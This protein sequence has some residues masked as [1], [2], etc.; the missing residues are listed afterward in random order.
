MIA[1]RFADFMMNE[2]MFLEEV[3]LTYFERSDSE[4]TMPEPMLESIPEP[5]PEPMPEPEP[6]PM[7]EQDEYIS[8][9]L[10]P[11]SSILVTTTTSPSQQPEDGAQPEPEPMPEVDAFDDADAVADSVFD[12]FSISSVDT[13]DFDMDEYVQRR[14]N[15]RQN[16]QL[17]EQRNKQLNEQIDERGGYKC[18]IC[19]DTCVDLRA[20]LCGHVFCRACLY[21]TFVEVSDK[22]PKCRKNF[23]LEEC[24]KVF[25]D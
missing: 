12:A 21:K 5:M 14:R 24:L 4:R 2:R 1:E 23:M 18:P 9:S 22:C 7:P 8:D 19:L 13:V 17:I 16:Q 6:E 11:R 15:E 20:P 3:M 25:F 10:T